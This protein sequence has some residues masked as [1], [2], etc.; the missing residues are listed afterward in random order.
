MRPDG[1]AN[2]VLAIIFIVLDTIAVALRIFAKRRIKRPLK[3]DD[4]WMVVALIFFYGWAALV[5]YS[6]I[7][8]SGTLQITEIVDLVD[9]SFVTKLLFVASFFFPFTITPLKIS[10]LG[11][12]RSVFPLEWFI[13]ATY[14]VTTLC[15][16]WLFS[17]F[18]TILFQCTPVRA[19]YD[20][21]P[22]IQ[23][24]A[25]CVKFGQFVFLTEILNSCLDVI[26][27][28]LPAFVVPS[29]H[30]SVRQRIQVMV[31]FLMGGFV[32]ITCVLRMF[33]TYNPKNP[34]AVPSYSKGMMWSTIQLG[35]AIICGNLPLYR[36]LLPRSEVVYPTVTSFISSARGAFTKNAVTPTSKSSKRNDI[37]DIDD[38]TQLTKGSRSTVSDE[39]S[40]VSYP[41]KAIPTESRYDVNSHQTV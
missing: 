29:L 33:Y 9:L 23:A 36:P 8:V 1:V 20:F 30:L 19:V 25:S 15:V 39:Q 26:I 32:L 5:I 41:L 18:W 31:V 40:H 38:E 4:V 27:L 6:V 13:R 11:F 37:H 12:Y 24:K 34:K 3:S 17:G 10:I 16:L 2:V 28:A 7:G 35:I 21:S 22:A 14:I